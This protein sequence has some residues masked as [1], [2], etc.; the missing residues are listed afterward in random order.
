[1]S[2]SSLNSR[3]NILSNFKNSDNSKIDFGLQINFNS[4]EKWDAYKLN[5]NHINVFIEK[6]STI[7]YE[8]EYSII[9]VIKYKRHGKK[10]IDREQKFNESKK[11]KYVTELEVKTNLSLEEYYYKNI[12][13]KITSKPNKECFYALSVNK[14]INI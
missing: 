10:F 12:K 5:N 6:L 8:K 14:K 7:T 9:D 13:E 11:S 1:M 2:T 4:I 3:F